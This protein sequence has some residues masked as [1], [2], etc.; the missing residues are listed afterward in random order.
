MEM[1]L[2]MAITEE[3]LLRLANRENNKIQYNRIYL[4]EEI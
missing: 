3:L 2:T 4:Y 1:R